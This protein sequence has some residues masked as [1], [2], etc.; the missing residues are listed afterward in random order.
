[1][2]RG[3]GHRYM[4]RID[5][6]R[7]CLCIGSPNIQELMLSVSSRLQR[8]SA[9]IDDSRVDQCHSHLVGG[10]P[11]DKCRDLARQTGP[12]SARI[13]VS[14]PAV[15]WPADMPRIDPAEHQVNQ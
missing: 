13:K 2:Q 3:K 15:E 6:R 11:A 14:H 9:A 7:N 8:D 12:A 1:T 10:E 5:L 4:C